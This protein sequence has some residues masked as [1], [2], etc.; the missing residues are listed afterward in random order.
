M[1]VALF[2]R[3]TLCYGKIKKG[4]GISQNKKQV[5]ALA[6]DMCSQTWLT[7]S[8]VSLRVTDGFALSNVP[9]K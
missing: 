8:S 2:T 7:G 3:L 4:P 1:F 5:Y 9:D 6:R